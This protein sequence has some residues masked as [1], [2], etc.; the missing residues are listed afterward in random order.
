[1]LLAGE[2]SCRGN[3][4]VPTPVGRDTAR[5]SGHGPWT[6]HAGSGRGLMTAFSKLVRVKI[7][8]ERALVLGMGLEALQGS[9]QADEAAGRDVK[10]CP[11][12]AWDLL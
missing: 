9:G 6:C 11:H 1:M 3:A 12:P 4:R 8:P 5:W 10:G 2:H 7:S